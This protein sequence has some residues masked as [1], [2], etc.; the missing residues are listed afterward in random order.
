MANSLGDRMKRYEQCTRYYLSIR[1]PV[2]IRLDGKAFHSLTNKM[3]KPYDDRFRDCMIFTGRA[4]CEKIQGVKFCYVQSD[5]I[6]L[7]LTDYETI[8]T[9]GWFEYTYQ[10]ICSVSASIAT[11]YF[12]RIFNSLFP[13]INKMAFFDSRCFNISKED[14]VNYFI[15]RQQ[16][17][18][19][20]SIQGLGQKYFSL[21]ELHK[22]SCNKIQDMLKVKKGIN[23]NDVPTCYKRGLSIYR[24]IDEITTSI[25]ANRNDKKIYPRK[26]K[27]DMESP[28]FTQ[29]RD[30][31]NK[32]VFI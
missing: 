26:W 3:K 24:E 4:L 6:S 31:I 5:E 16:D 32:L 14:V 13:E 23:W 2:I 27:V 21:K 15:W 11:A 10:K 22:K 18:T 17:A 28:I 7:L 25:G 12:N 8:T 20:N 9:Q 29:N 19:R 30:Y 1:I